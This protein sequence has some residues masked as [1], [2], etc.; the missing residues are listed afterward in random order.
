MEDKLVEVKEKF[1]KKKKEG[2]MRGRK[3]RM[4]I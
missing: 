4:L 2:K 3:R 1:K